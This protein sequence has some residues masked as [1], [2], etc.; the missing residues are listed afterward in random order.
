MKFDVLIQNGTLIDGTGKKACAGA[1]GVKD[2]TIDEIGPRVKGNATTV[3]D[4]TG[5]IVCPGFIDMTNHSDTHWTLFDYPSQASMLRQGITSIIGGSCG[6]SLAPLIHGSVSAES[7]QKWVD[8]SQINVNWLRMKEFFEELQHHNVGVHFGTL[9]GHSTLRRNI[10]HDA[11]RLANISEIERMGYLLDQALEEHAFGLSLGL[12][13]SHGRS[14]ADEEI[15]ELAKVVASRDRLLTIHLRDEGKN[16]LP[17]VTEVLRIARTSGVRVH[18]VHFKALGRESWSQLARALQLIRAGREE[19]LDITVST[20][21]YKRTGSLL[22]TLLPA[23]NR[24]GGKDMILEA[25]KNPSHRRLLAGNL[26]GATLHYEKIIVASAKHTPQFAGK[27]IAELAEHWALRPEEAFLEILAVNELAVTIFSETI[28]EKNMETI[29]RQPYAYF[30]SDGI[31]YEA[32]GNTAESTG[33]LVHPRSFGAS[34]RFLADMVRTKSLLSWEDAISKMTLAPAL[35]L[36][37]RDNRGTLQK[38]APADITL[39]DPAK[40]KDNATYE[41]PFQYPTGI[42]WVLVGGKVAVANNEL[43][44]VRSGTILQ[45]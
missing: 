6:T 21:P 22:Y 33:N 10:M 17:A 38:D 28:N 3:I 42:P 44:Q 40:I 19:G 30:A 26:N 8:V 27:S 4:A 29:Y 31:G 37:L 18:I 41:H 23:T 32:P 9:V 13:F 2:G 45:A 7:I 11:V 1:I 5:L 20:F 24:D 14:A 25:I 35:L 43:T 34:A 36:R 12:M 39:F 15:T 16:I